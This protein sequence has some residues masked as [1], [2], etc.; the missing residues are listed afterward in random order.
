MFPKNR[1]QF[2]ERKVQ[3]AFKRIRQGHSEYTFFTDAVTFFHRPYVVQ[4]RHRLSLLPGELAGRTGN[5]AEILLPAATVRV[6]NAE[7][8]NAGVHRLRS[9]L[10]TPFLPSARHSAVLETTS[11]A[12]LLARTVPY[13]S[14][15]GNTRYLWVKYSSRHKMRAIKTERFCAKR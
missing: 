10:H 12:V 6:R 2:R 3:A 14:K 4:I 11:P 1:L 9:R 13:W 7:L 5:I 8:F 15:N